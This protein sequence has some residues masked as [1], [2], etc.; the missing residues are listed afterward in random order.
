[1]PSQ[2][3]KIRR[4]DPIEK[5]KS[6]EKYKPDAFDKIWINHIQEGKIYFGYMIHNF[7]SMFDGETRIKHF[8]ILPCR[9]EEDLDKIKE[10]YSD[11][12]QKSL[13]PWIKKEYEEGRLTN[14]IYWKPSRTADHVYIHLGYRKIF[15]YNQY[16]YQVSL[17]LGCEDCDECKDCKNSSI[18]PYIVHFQLIYYNNTNMIEEYVKRY[19]LTLD[20][21]TQ[22]DMMIPNE[23]WRRSAK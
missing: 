16:Y 23:Y 2:T 12:I 20:M 19:S 15:E 10:V 8:D 7:K 3:R 18:K 22:P 9:Y 5:V 6:V 17:N 1:M 13:V 21:C 4:E 14:Y 11:E